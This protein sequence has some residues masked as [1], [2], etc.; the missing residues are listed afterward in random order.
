MQ[1]LKTIHLHHPSNFSYNHL[2]FLSRILLKR[3]KRNSSVAESQAFRC[4]KKR[5]I[6]NCCFCIQI[7]INQPRQTGIR[8]S[9]RQQLSLS[10]VSLGLQTFVQTTWGCRIRNG[11]TMEYLEPIFDS[12]YCNQ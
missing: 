7:K 1:T 11:Q 3:W 9:H 12:L 5:S 6:F 10:H 8:L 2:Q 4:I